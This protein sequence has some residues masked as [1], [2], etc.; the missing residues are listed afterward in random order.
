[1][2]FYSEIFRNETAGACHER[3][4]RP[5][6]GNTLVPESGKRAGT[7]LVSNVVHGYEELHMGAQKNAGSVPGRG[8]TNTKITYKQE[9]ETW[10]V[11]P[12]ST[13]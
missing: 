7:G 13:K 12:T 3:S 6:R 10:T 2:P 11:S 8:V 5:S 9:G 4:R 1:M